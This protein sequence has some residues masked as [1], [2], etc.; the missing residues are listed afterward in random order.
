R[1]AFLRTFRT[2]T[3]ISIEETS[4]AAGAGFAGV[5]SL[6]LMYSFE[7][8]PRVPRNSTSTQPSDS[9][10]MLACSPAFIWVRTEA[11]KFG[12]ARTFSRL[13]EDTAVWL[14][15]VSVVSV[16]LVSQAAIQ[17]VSPEIDTSIQSPLLD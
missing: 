5:I 3:A 14:A 15:A 6:V 4:L 8:N 1:S 7:T 9:L 13:T 2:S 17:P 10:R 16:V 12:C 11:D